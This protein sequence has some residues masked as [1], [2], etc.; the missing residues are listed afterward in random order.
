ME[1]VTHPGKGVLNDTNGR[2]VGEAHSHGGPQRRVNTGG[3]SFE[4]LDSLSSFPTEDQ[5]VAAEL[6]SITAIVKGVKGIR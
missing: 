6:Y 5:Q 3:V 2:G 1:P 4:L